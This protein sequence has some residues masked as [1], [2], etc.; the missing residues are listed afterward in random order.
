MDVRVDVLRSAVAF[1]VLW[2]KDNRNLAYPT[3]PYN[4]IMSTVHI[5]TTARPDDVPL[6][7]SIE[8]AAARLLVGHAPESVLRET[9]SQEELKHAQS[10][11]LL[12]VALENDVPVGFAHVELLESFVAHLKEI[13]VHPQYGRRGLGTRLIAAVCA[14][15]A[16]AGCQAVTLTTFRDVAWNMPFYARLGFHEIPFDEVSAALMSVLRDEARKGLDP[17]RRVAMERLCSL[18]LTAEYLQDSRRPQR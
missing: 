12:W 17:A 15:A 9:S 18:P 8:L 10:Q 11:G 1:G 3:I 6:L 2:Q 4:A 16:M 13:D 5:I 7:P 14:W